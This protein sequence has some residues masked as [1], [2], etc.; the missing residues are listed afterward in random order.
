MGDITKTTDSLSQAVAATVATSVK[1]APRAVPARL[2]DILALDDFERHSKPLLPRMIY[3][4]VAGGV[5][6]ETAMR[7]GRQA[8]QDYGFTPRALVDTSARSTQTRLFGKVYSAPFAIG[9]LGGA[10]FVAYRADLALAAAARSCTIPMIL[11]ASSLIR[12][13]DV[14]AVNPDAWFQG[15]L[16]GDFDRI[17]RMLERV[18]AA[19]Y[20]NLVV[21]VDTPILGNREH[22]IRT[23]FSMPIRITPRVMVQSATHPRWLLGTVA[24]TF[25][26]HGA[27]HFEN[28]EAERGPPMMSRK[29]RNTVARDKLTWEHIAFIR[30]R[31]AGPLIIKGIISPRDAF[32]ARDHG[33][34]GIVLSSHGG[35]QLDHA[36]A[37]LRV[38]PEIA[39]SKGD[40]KIIIDGGIRRGS[41]VLK[42]LAL[43]ADFTLMGRPFLFAAA[44]DG[45]RGVEHAYT[46]MHDEL[47][48]NMAMLGVNTTD[49][50]NENFVRKAGPALS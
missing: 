1:A 23:G 30:K 4:Y 15:Y 21:T 32:T 49:E 35:R 8:Y 11:S 7:N 47:M 14:I 26:K 45:Q 39:A 18:K 16:A 40:M 12:L 50:L 20:K 33:A 34:D 17:E 6:T 37:P 48:R 2:R 9:P 31:W 44:Y 24:K 13:E 10:A 29:L 25:L 19:G 3:Q 42:A 46:I 41:D 38:L 43:G 5:E 22:N 28:T 36:M 27:P